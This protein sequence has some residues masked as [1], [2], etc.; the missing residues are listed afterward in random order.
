MVCRLGE[1]FWSITS[2]ISWKR[3]YHSE[4]ISK[5]RNLKNEVVHGRK[6]NSRWW[7]WKW[8]RR[9]NAKG[10]LESS[11]IQ[12]SVIKDDG[13]SMLPS[14]QITEGVQLVVTE[15]QSEKPRKYSKYN[16][17]W[18]Y[19]RRIQLWKE[20]VWSSSS[21]VC[22]RPSIQV[23]SYHEREDC[24]I[25]KNGTNKE[26]RTHCL[27]AIVC[28]RRMIVIVASFS[29]LEWIKK[30]KKN[31]KKV[32]RVF[33]MVNVCKWAPTLLERKHDWS[34]EHLVEDTENHRCCRWPRRLRVKRISGQDVAR[35]RLWD[36]RLWRWTAEIRRWLSGFCRAACPCSCS[37]RVYRGIAICGSGVGH[38]LSPTKYQ[39]CGRA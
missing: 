16:S 34:S 4:C 35:G 15:S 29:S 28:G 8:N 13:G 38:V 32:T 20:L 2:A 36:N 24:R 33:S 19:Q 25:Y 1:R 37:R 22:L 31:L 30:M 10:H 27:L 26:Y 6:T 3:K 5:Y 9:W 18:P 7:I 39:V 23:W 14:M 21:L 17:Y 11:G 12:A